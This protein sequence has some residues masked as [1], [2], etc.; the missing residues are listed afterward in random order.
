MG[1]ERKFSFIDGIALLFIIFILFML[2]GPLVYPRHGREAARRSDCRA[3]LHN[4]GLGLARWRAD[5]G[6]NYPATV[7][8]GF[9]ENMICDA[10]GRIFSEGYCN[11]EDVYICAST[12]L[13]LILHSISRYPGEGPWTENAAVLYN[14]LGAGGDLAIDC[15]TDYAFMLNSSYNYDNGRIHKDSAAGRIVA[16]DGLWRQWMHNAGVGSLDSQQDWMYEGA[17]PNHDDGA[18]VLYH[19]GSVEYVKTKLM[20]NYWIPYQADATLAGSS[21]SLET[22]PD[23]D[24]AIIGPDRPCLG[25]TYD[26]VRQG[27]IQNERIEEDGLANGSAE[28]DDAYASEGVPGNPDVPE[29]WWMLSEFQFETS[30]LIGGKDWVTDGHGRITDTKSSTDGM[31]RVARSKIDASIQPPRHYRPGTGRPD[32]ARPDDACDFGLPIGGRVAGDMWEY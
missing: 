31:V 2:F 12:E 20:Y 3:C 6:G 25:A 8:Y 32:D 21:T 7:K 16:G 29:Q 9:K 23:C 18:N 28:H 13:R 24:T 10:W 15:D 22:E 14:L 4:I 1:S 17:E 26:W 11:D 5:H 27:V 19:D 30:I